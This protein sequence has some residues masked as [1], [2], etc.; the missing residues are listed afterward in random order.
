MVTRNKRKK[1][2]T[3]TVLYC[4]GKQIT[5]I[6]D[7]GDLS[8]NGK[9]LRYFYTVLVWTEFK[10]KDYPEIKLLKIRFEFLS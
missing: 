5:L 2:K 6:V 7:K 1:K 10:R 8:L 9:T 3:M 4:F